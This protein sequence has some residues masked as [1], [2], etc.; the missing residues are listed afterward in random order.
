MSKRFSQ[1]E[2]AIRLSKLIMF[3]IVLRSNYHVKIGNPD[4]PK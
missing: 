4:F 3:I 2:Y 1:L